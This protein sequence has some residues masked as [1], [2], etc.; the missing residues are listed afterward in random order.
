MQ[1][2]ILPINKCKMTASWKTTAYLSKYKV[3]HY[4]ADL[5]SSTGSADGK[6]SF[7]ASG[8][9]LVMAA[10]RDNVVGNVVAVLYE[11]SLHRPT[12]QYRNVVFRYYHLDKISVK[13]GQSVTKDT[14]IG[15]YG[16]T[17]SL[18][19]GKHL[20]LEADTDVLFPLWSPTVRQSNLI[21]G[22]VR[23]ANDRTMTNPT[24]WLHQKIS[25][26]DFQIWSTTNDQY[27]RAEDKSIPA[28]K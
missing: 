28:V 27:I 7:Y 9:G 5:I 18:T 12:G 14:V 10:G 26:P 23:G 24:E 25:G 8:N 21:I 20:H 1:K 17:G 13:A 15:E 16:N 22:T 2:L 3:T 19:M 11:N 4:G 6:R